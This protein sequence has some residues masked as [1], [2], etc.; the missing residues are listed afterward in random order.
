MWVDGTYPNYGLYIKNNNEG[1]YRYHW[2]IL[3][4]YYSD[5]SLG[6]YL[7]IIYEGGQKPEEKTSGH[8]IRSG[9]TLYSVTD[10]TLTALAETEITASLFQTYGVDEI[11]DGAL[12]ATLTDPEVLFWQDS[13]D[14]LPDLSL[15]VTGTPPLPQVITSD[16]VDL[17]HE[18]ISAI[19]HVTANASEDVR[20]SVS[21]NGGATWLAYNGSG[22]VQTTETEPGMLASTMNA[23]TTAQWAEIATL[24]SCMVRAWLPAVTSYVDSVVFHYINP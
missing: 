18:S 15:T 14:D 8:I 6:S 17:A 2:R 10:G 4:H 23:I 19:D 11:Q 12:L 20:F 1:S 21:F 13:Q 3:N 22:W 9:S 16:S 5:A 24:T 7:E